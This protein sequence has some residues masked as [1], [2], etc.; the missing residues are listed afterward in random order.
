MEKR[1]SLSG[2]G[3]LVMVLCAAWL[4][5]P[6]AAQVQQPGEEAR[7]E[8]LIRVMVADLTVQGGQTPEAV[9]EGF[10][11]ILPQVVDCIEK[12]YERVKKLPR[13]IMLRLNLGSNGKV[14]WSK[15]VDP[16]LKSLDACV[17]KVLQQMQLPPTGTTISRVTIVLETRT[18]HLLSP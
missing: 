3:L 10:N 7:P 2:S 13:K 5:L 4:V 14:A 6:V 1:K 9:R 8:P 11:A 12:E 18:D 17:A 16:P 15:V